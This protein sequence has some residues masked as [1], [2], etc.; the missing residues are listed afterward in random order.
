MPL[1]FSVFCLMG[2][3]YYR[4]ILDNIVMNGRFLGIVLSAFILLAWGNC[5]TFAQE[6]ATTP[7]YAQRILLTDTLG[8]G[9]S[10]EARKVIGR[11]FNPLVHSLSDEYGWLTD[12]LSAP[13]VVDAKS[14]STFSIDVP[15][16][17]LN[18]DGNNWLSRFISNVNQINS[19]HYFYSLSHNWHN[20]QLMRERIMI[21]HPYMPSIAVSDLPG[22]IV[23][24]EIHSD[25]YQG[26]LA[27]NDKPQVTTSEAL[28]TAD[29]I[30]RK[31]WWH[32]FESSI[33]FAENQVSKNWHKGGHNSLNLNSRIYYNATYERDLLKWVNE[34][35][36]RIGVFTNEMGESETLKLK[37]G[38]DAFRINSNVGV[39]AFKDWYYTFDVQLRSQILKNTKADGMVIT[40]PFAPIVLDAG[41]GMKYDLDIKEF[42][43]NPYA[44]L[45]L[46]AN[47][48][49]IA[50]NF[51]YT[52]SNNID[53]GRIG[54]EEDEKYRLRLGS[55]FRFDLNWDI[56]SSFNWT[57]R[58]FFSTSYKHVEVEYD[59]SLSYAFSRFFSTRITL[60]TRF[61]DSVILPEDTPKTFKNLLQYNQLLSIGFEYKF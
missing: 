6:F 33:H 5:T 41:L 34:L 56:S 2:C 52:Y 51:L 32:K 14:Y 1:R 7:E 11:P 61:D 48:A 47:A 28:L 60:N 46:A 21:N 58:L 27:R 44:R 43:G 49:P 9:L 19:A 36:Y 54:L 13:L 35:E 53:K 40:L 38:E 57:S 16:K 55:A 30:E 3:F 25:G 42:R 12:Y 31:Y 8:K 20:A 45:R 26:E 15:E 4:Y 23:P 10:S 37:I 59:N 18:N 24:T 39:K 22:A 50:V 29:K 17:D